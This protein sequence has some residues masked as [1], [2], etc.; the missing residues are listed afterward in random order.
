MERLLYVKKYSVDDTVF[1]ICN[2]YR[3]KVRFRLV[4]Y[5]LYIPNLCRVNGYGS[6]KWFW[7]SKTDEY[8]AILQFEIAAGYGAMWGYKQINENEFDVIIQENNYDSFQKIWFDR[9]KEFIGGGFH[10]ENIDLAKKIIVPS[11]SACGE[12]S[13]EEYYGQY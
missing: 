6:D 9:E 7:L 8:C 2:K 4:G 10:P 3:E 13:D 1:D 5:A 12:I 11:Y